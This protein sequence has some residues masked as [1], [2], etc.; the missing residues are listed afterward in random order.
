MS[1]KFSDVSRTVDKICDQI[2]LAAITVPKVQD[3]PD[4]FDCISD[5]ESATSG[6][7]DEQVLLALDRSFSIG[8]YRA[9]LQAIR[10]KFTTIRK[11]FKW[12]TIKPEVIERYADVEVTT[13]YLTKLQS[14]KFDSGRKLYDFVEDVLFLYT[15]A[16]PLEKDA[17]LKIR[18]VKTILPL[19]VKKA[20]LTSNYYQDPSSLEEFMRSMKLYDQIA[21]SNPGNEPDERKSLV[22]AEDLVQLLQGITKRLDQLELRELSTALV[23][24]AKERYA[25]PSRRGNS[26]PRSADGDYRRSPSPMRR[27]N[28]PN[29]HPSSERHE[30][31][32]DRNRFAR[33]K[34]PG[35]P[36][37]RDATT[38]EP[39]AKPETKRPSTMGC[40]SP[41]LANL[42]LHAPIVRRFIG[43]SIVR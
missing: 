43:S 20:L 5:F 4:I 23:A 8:R 17:S 11:P 37:S 26:P 29:K 7:N 14:M 2:S 18:Y 13:R 3:Y 12:S 9:W 10:E 16:F 35:R 42:H 28:S 34:R 32:R 27:P 22:K 1:I 30:H 36:R 15:R 40:I 39:D 21:G 38:R 33:D 24:Y 31:R 41:S 19:H 25:S 6:L